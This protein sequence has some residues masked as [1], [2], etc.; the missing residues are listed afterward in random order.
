MKQSSFFR[1][2]FLLVSTFALTVQS[3]EAQEGGTPPADF[4]ASINS[5]PVDRPMN[6]SDRFGTKVVDYV[7]DGIPA[8]RLDFEHPSILMQNGIPE[9]WQLSP[10]NTGTSSISFVNRMF[11]SASFSISI[12]KKGVY[13]KDSNATSMKA[14]AASLINKHG[15]NMTFESWQTEE[16]KDPK[17]PQTMASFDAKAIGY[18][19]IDQNNKER[20]HR[21][22]F[23][24]FGDWIFEVAFQCD[25]TAYDATFEAFDSY[26]YNLVITER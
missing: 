17:M 24:E 1:I 9:D 4:A 6:V 7:W 3:T 2:S 12:F 5:I 16:F 10:S 21:L 8:S 19:L 26:L 15:G 11:Q 25:A 20:A 18:T 13:L 14:V 23:F 22:Y